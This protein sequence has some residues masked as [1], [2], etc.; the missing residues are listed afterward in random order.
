MNTPLVNPPPAVAL[1]NYPSAIGVAL[2]CFFTAALLIVAGKFDPTGGTLTLSLMITLGML[3]ATAYCL[4]FTIPP[5]DITPGI[6]GGLTAGFGAV[7]AHWL[8]RI[9]GRK[10][11]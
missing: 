3:G 9:Q 10:D 2:I 7:V 4:I 8:G 6:V 11:E 5:D 1:M